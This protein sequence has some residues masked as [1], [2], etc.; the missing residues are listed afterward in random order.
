[1]TA[2][3]FNKAIAIVNGE[4]V[5]VARLVGGKMVLTAKG[6]ELAKTLKSD[7]KPKAA[8]PDN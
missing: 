2:Y 1:M 3:E 6:E 8:D 5:F 4:R 7:P